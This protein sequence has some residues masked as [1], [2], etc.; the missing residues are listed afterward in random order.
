MNIIKKKYEQISPTID[1]LSDEVILMHAWKKTNNYIRKH[2]WY[3]DV[4]ELDITVSDIERKIKDYSLTLKEKTYKPRS[5]QLVLAPKNNLWNFYFDEALNREVWK[6]RDE[7]GQLRPLAHVSIKDQT[8]SSAIM[9]CLANA[10][11]TLQG[12]TEETNFFTA[13]KKGVFSYGNRLQC[14]WISHLNKKDQAKFN[15]GNS[16]IYRQYFEDYKKFLKRPQNICNFLSHT[17]NRENELYVISLDLQKFYDNIDV[18]SLLSELKNHYK[19]YSKL[20]DLNK[21]NAE[22]DDEFW[23]KSEEIMNWSWDLS[24]QEL[25]NQEESIDLKLGLPQGLVASGFFSN[26]YMIKFDKLMSNHLNKI[27]DN[28][29][30]IV[31]YCRYVDDLRIVVEAPEDTDISII[32]NKIIE[33]VKKNLKEHQ[34]NINSTKEIDINESKTKI[35]SFRQMSNK[36]NVSSI[37]NMIQENIS[38]TPDFESLQQIT[39]ELMSKLNDPYYENNINNEEENNK[40]KI[41]IHSDLLDLSRIYVPYMDIQDDTLKRF[42]ATRLVKTMRLK[43]RMT[44]YNEVVSIDKVHDVVIT[45]GQLIDHEIES[46]AR[47]LISVWSKNPSLSLLLKCGLDLYPDKS[48]LNPVIQ[49]LESKLFPEKNR[50]ENFYERKTAEYVASDLL[51]FAATSLGYNNLETYP[52]S[53]NINRFKEELAAFS[54]RLLQSENNF[55]WYVKQQA[56]LFLV[57]NKDYGFSIDKNDENLVNYYLLKKISI[58]DF[59]FDNINLDQFKVLSISL[60]SQQISKNSEKFS[61]WFLNWFSNRHNS[62]AEKQE[63]LKVLR[64]N[65]FYLFKKVLEVDSE[66]KYISSSIISKKYREYV[67]GDKNIKLENIGSRYVFLNEIITS[68]NNPFNTENASIKL[69]YAIL[70]DDNTKEYVKSGLSVNNIKVSCS[71]WNEIQNPYESI[72]I[73]WVKS[74]A[75]SNNKVLEDTEKVPIW[76]SEEKQW[77]Y[78]VGIF[79]RSC[80]VSQYDF[81]YNRYKLNIDNENYLGLKTNSFIRTF[82]MVNNS[83][84]LN[85]SQIPITPWLSNFLFQLLQWPGIKVN[86]FIFDNSI[87]L[88][89]QE[90][91]NIIEE[92]IKVQKS[93][94][95]KLSKTPIYKFPIN[96]KKEGSN[97][98]LKVVTVQPLLPQRKDFNEKD[99]VNWSNR[100]K[101]KHRNH[102]ASLCNLISKQIIATT[103]AEKYLEYNNIS[104]VDIIIFP[105]LSINP[106]DIDLLHALS[107]K[108]KA[109]IFAGLTFHSKEDKVINE[110]LWILRN[111]NQSGREFVHI[112]QGKKHLT[113]FEKQIKVSSYRPYQVLIEMKLDNKKSIN[114]SGAICYD[115]TD[116]SIVADLRDLSDVF[117]IAAMNQDVQTFDNMI[118]YLH[119]H[120]Y[121]PVIL[122]N[123][124]EFGGSSVQAPYPGHEKRIFHV[125]GNQQIAVNVFEVDPYAFKLNEKPTNIPNL[126]TP[127]AGYEGRK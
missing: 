6:P 91:I 111:D 52:K 65:N 62:K 32:Q 114:L 56:I 94:Y 122:V 38:G 2:N 125:H 60:V 49:A 103:S 30:K 79:L 97:K 45:A 77:V 59:N 98:N 72:K 118:N 95:G 106:E 7:K 108:T 21:S 17:L 115:A 110:A 64:L 40:D 47:K 9:V 76:I 102:L 10:I 105:E 37:M 124:G 75:F 27:S 120:M 117:I 29:L 51:R 16:K 55:S 112:Y 121:Q 24:S 48:L 3:V 93:L 96:S 82:S 70:N 13:Q 22:L 33:I 87:D 54:K 53:V 83:K 28:D 43:K 113:Y 41:N 23:N 19:E 68:N 44:V 5:A 116:L 39:G 1:F 14:D 109:H 90:L 78:K 80:L 42:S 66:Y 36:S 81:T 89:V 71:N 107:D 73:K 100:Y 20:Y 26:A 25:L 18:K 46:V 101:E 11:E 58:F 57:V 86:H 67:T 8:Y 50:Q 99:P 123:T 84:G 74:N 12:S 69:L 34:K 15:W 119:Y 126:K 63:L 104:D 85:S 31:D 92:R 61:Y 88:N 127:P 4:L 35:I